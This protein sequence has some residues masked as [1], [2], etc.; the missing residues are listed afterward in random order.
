M[1]PWLVVLG[2]AS[3]CGGQQ[4][5]RERAPGVEYL[6]AMRI[7]GNH[8]LETGALEPGLA[9]HEVI[10]DG[11]VLDPYLLT[12]DA[13]RIRV[14]Y[15]RCGF[16]DARVEHRVLHRGRAQIVVFTITEGRRAATRVEIIGLPPELPPAS[17]RALV[18][19][20]DGTPFDYDTYEAA[21]QPLTAL[22]TNAGYAHAEISGKVTAD[23]TAAIAMVRYEIR[24][25]VRCTF[26]DVKIRLAGHLQE[27]LEPSLEAAVRARVRFATGDWYSAAALEESQ[28]EI[29]ELGRFST[30]Q[31]GLDHRQC[32]AVG[33]PVVDVAVELALANRHELH[34]GGGFG[35]EPATYEARLRGGYRLVPARLP[36]ATLAADARV[37]LTIPHDFDQEQLE[38]K[39]RARV[40]LQYL[41][42]I[43][44]RLRGEVEAGADYQTV[45][46]YTWTGQHVRLG[47]GSPLGP[48]WLQLRVG[49][50]LEHLQ[51]PASKI[52]DAVDEEA[53]RKLGLDRAQLRGVYQASLAADL[54]DHPIEPHRGIYA[55]L[56]VT[57]GTRLAG[58][59]LTYLQLTPELRGYV[60]LGG[61][62]IAARA[63][64]GA[65]LGDVPVTERYY[66]GGTSGQR[67]FS[68]RQL[69]PTVPSVCMDMKPC[70]EIGGAGLVEAGVELRRQLGT[71]WALPVGANLFLD[72]GDVTEHPEDLDPWRLHWAV[73][74]GGWTKLVGDLKLRIDVGY[75][76]NRTGSTEPSFEAGRF[77]KIAPHIGVGE[78]Y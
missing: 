76:L 71:L 54:R 19:L 44:P 51:F 28:A 21:K 7:E 55:D 5:V 26:G 13:E 12:V 65:I 25:G 62:V 52:N 6:E 32:A 8:A 16:W 10:R 37:A 63:R 34:A 22:V 35:Y 11:G 47:L 42:L 57:R 49:W 39:V 3:A 24:P 31:V 72:G 4:R 74:I 46:A 15:L 50:V 53:R 17:A 38:P 43:W 27:S 2:I 29:Y 75:R 14:A 70:V 73:G 66:S 1:G 58:G 78:V 59:D 77:A 45:E 60:S 41:D 36:L 69:S 56:R 9:L 64:V 67:G 18:G 20:G 40:S 48:R 68:D 61:T 30:V 23:P 33:D